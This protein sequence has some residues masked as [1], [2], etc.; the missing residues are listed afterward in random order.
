MRAVSGLRLTVVAAILLGSAGTLSAQVQVTQLL[1][2]GQSIAG[3]GTFQQAIR[4][5]AGTN[6]GWAS[7]IEVGAAHNDVVMRNG[8]VIVPSG[9]GSFGGNSI[10]GLSINA[11]GDV[12]TTAYVA[13]T[14]PNTVFDQNTIFFNSQPVVVPS[15]PANLPGFSSGA[16]WYAVEDAVIN[17]NRD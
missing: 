11:L 8:S 3:Y 12:A 9:G 14:Y 16:Y 5:A 17:D 2:Q 4:M 15:Q 7:R 6:G 10:F 1:G 13:G